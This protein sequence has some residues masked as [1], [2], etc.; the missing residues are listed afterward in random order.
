MPSIYR[1]TQAEVTHLKGDSGSK[2]YL[3]LSQKLEHKNYHLYFDNF[4]SSVSL[5]SELLAK[6]I[7]ACGT[8]TQNFLP[9]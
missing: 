9:H 8:A 6:G 1:S 5:M 2:L 3:D 4:F 7:Y